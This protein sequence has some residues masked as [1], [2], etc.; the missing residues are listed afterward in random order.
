MIRQLLA[1]TAA[2]ALLTLGV[3]CEQAASTTTKATD[4]AK[5]VAKDATDKAKDAADKAKDAVK[6]GAA[7][8]TEMTKEAMEKAKATFLEPIEKMFPDVDKKIQALTGDGK[9]KATELLAA[10]KKLIEDFKAAPGD[11][12]QGLMQ[13]ITD[14][15]A[16]LKKAAGM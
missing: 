6:D 4:K 15:V 12:F 11:K 16:E 14:K 5:D 2:A 3:G 10:L 1:G 9:T 7:K 13:G 8:A